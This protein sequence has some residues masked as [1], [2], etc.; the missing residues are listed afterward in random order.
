MHRKHSITFSQPTLTQQH[1]KDQVDINNIMKRYIKTGVL[2]HVAKYKPQYRDNNSIDYQESMNIVIKADEMFSE[3]PAQARK[4][5]NN[6]PAAFLDFVQDPANH[7]KLHE[8]GLTEIPI[9]TTTTTESPP[10][11]PGKKT[12]TKS[13]TAP[14]ATD[15][16]KLH[17][18]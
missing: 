2:D 15:A 12:E 16:S 7:D 14:A 18:K 3:L 13:E 5:F 4:Q 10:P 8:L 11:S 1:S 9:P 17:D 6:D